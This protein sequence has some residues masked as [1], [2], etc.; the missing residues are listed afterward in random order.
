M[1]K[2]QRW[3]PKWPGLKFTYYACE[4]MREERRSKIMAMA[5]FLA[6]CLGLVLFLVARAAPYIY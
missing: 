6:I 3:L 1:S 4:K 5:I 2:K